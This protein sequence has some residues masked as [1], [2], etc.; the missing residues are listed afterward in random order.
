M[1]DYGTFI[2]RERKRKGLRQRELAEGLCTVDTIS[3]IEKGSQIPSSVLFRLLIERLGVSGFSHGDFFGAG[4]IKLMQLQNYIIRA[5]DQKKMENIPI[6][7]G[8]YHD[9]MEN[10]GWDEQFFEYAKGWYFFCMTKES[11][12]F[13]DACER[14]MR[15]IH[16]DFVS[17]EDFS[18]KQ[19]IQNEYRILNSQAV[20]WYLNGESAKACV[21]LCRLISNQKR[22]KDIF[23]YYWRNLAILYNNLAM[24][25]RRQYPSEAVSHMRMAQKAVTISGNPLMCLRVFR[26]KLLHFN[27]KGDYHTMTRFL[28]KCFI[29]VNS[30]LNVY[31][32]FW[33]FLSESCMLNIL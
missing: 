19:L 10:G 26:T 13:L 8:E 28:N 33:D 22:G 29:E 31:E 17:E 32:D 12:E 7:L 4:S 21:Q 18:L 1:T 5:L 23:P 14:A 30:Q 24:S 6:L 11:E 27:T 3:R 25:E 15:V 2:R 9:H 20:V 16:C